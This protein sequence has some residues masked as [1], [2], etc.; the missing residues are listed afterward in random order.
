[1]ES[2]WSVLSYVL[3][4]AGDVEGVG[5]SLPVN[6][7]PKTSSS[8]GPSSLGVVVLVTVRA[9]GSMLGSLAIASSCD[10]ML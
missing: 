9:E 10:C 2:M 1:M 7:R 5:G 8:G 6:V 3:V 4:F